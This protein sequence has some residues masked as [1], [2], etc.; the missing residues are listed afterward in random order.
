MVNLV[1]G[2]GKIPRLAELVDEMGAQIPDLVS[3][4]HTVNDSPAEVAYGDTKLVWGVDHFEEVL[5]GVRLKVGP[6]SFLQTNSEMAEI[7]YA[8]AIEL[9]QLRPDDVVWDLYSGIGSISLAMAP[10]VKHVHGIEVVEE[11]VANAIENAELNGIDNVTFQVG[12]V[13]PALKFIDYDET[14]QPDVIVVDPPRS[15]LSI[16][17]VRRIC[18]RQPRAVVYVSCNPTT[19]AGNLPM[20]AEHGYQL[21][22]AVPVDQFPHTPHVELV[23]RLEPIPGFEPA[24]APQA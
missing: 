6:F 23:A 10:H 24:Q 1:T 11:A 16:K 8:H 12:N 20:F 4:F 22:E 19:F 5:A 7:A 18:E 13:R 3:F 14:P 2:P 21:V 15:G 9:A 17:V